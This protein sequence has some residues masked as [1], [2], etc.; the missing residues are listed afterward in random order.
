MR[1][2]LQFVQ[3]R[4]TRWQPTQTVYVAVRQV[5][6]ASAAMET[7]APLPHVV[8]LMAAKNYDGVV[9][10]YEAS[11]YAD[12]MSLQEFAGGACQARDMAVCLMRTFTALGRMDRVREVFTVGLRD[13]AG[14]GDGGGRVVPLLNTSF[15]NAYLEVLTQRKNFSREEVMFVLR[16]M[17]A[18]CVLPDALTYHYL[19]E[20]HIRMGVDPVGLWYDMRRGSMMQP[21]PCTVQVLLLH[22]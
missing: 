16:E 5:H 14:G 3:F 12:R 13:F 21:L 17:K 9:R 2:P 4:L 19:I 8:E 7:V 18:V 6:G 22:V 20:L 10:F 1:R 15:F 11:F